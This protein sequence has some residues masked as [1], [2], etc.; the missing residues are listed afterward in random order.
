MTRTAI[1]RSHL[2][3]P[4]PTPRVP[5]V[6]AVEPDGF[7]RV[8]APEHVDVRCVGLLDVF[9][10]NRT[11]AEEYAMLSLPARHK[12]FAFDARHVRGCYMPSPRTAEEEWNRITDVC[13]LREVQQ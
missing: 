8:F 3:P 2:S 5:V 7:L 6:V 12:P 9:P 10:E 1:L 13:L 4:P 11:D